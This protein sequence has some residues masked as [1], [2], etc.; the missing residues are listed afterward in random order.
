MATSVIKRRKEKKSGDFIKMPEIS[1]VDLLDCVMSDR[2]NKSA[3]KVMY[4]FQR[5]DR[6]T[7]GE[8]GVLEGGTPAEG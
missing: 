3:V 1:S 7:D 2:S 8:P 5:E 4:G 6:L